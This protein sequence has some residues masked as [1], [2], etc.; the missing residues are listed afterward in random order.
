MGSHD[1][2]ETRRDIGNKRRYPPLSFS[3]STQDNGYLYRNICGSFFKEEEG[4]LTEA[5]KNWEKDPA[6]CRNQMDNI[7]EHTETQRNEGCWGA[8]LRTRPDVMHV[9][10]EPVRMGQLTSCR[11][12]RHHHHGPCF[13]CCE[14]PRRVKRREEAET[15]LIDPFKVGQWA[16]LQIF[17]R[18]QRAPQREGLWPRPQLS[19]VCRHGRALVIMIGF[20]FVVFF[21]FRGMLRQAS[22]Q[23]PFKQKW[24]S[25]STIFFRSNYILKK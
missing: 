5:Y 25:S 17:P 12:R 7:Q 15:S 10:H 1:L 20:F 13:V 23:P 11:H 24:V 6:G 16:H 19:S 3:S 9:C 18:S 21:F 8:H 4:S 22:C 14:E 2:N